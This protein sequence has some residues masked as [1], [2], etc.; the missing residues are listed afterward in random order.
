MA[1][2]RVFFDG[3]IRWEEEAL[4]SP[5]CTGLLYGDGLF[6]VLRGYDGVPFRLTD[7]YDRLRASC[8]ALRL[9]LLYD[10][11]NLWLIIRELLRQND[12]TKGDS[13][14]RIT[15]FGSEL[16]TISS[17]DGLTTHTF[18]HVRPFSPPRPVK[19]RTGVKVRVSSYRTS[20]HNPTAGHNTICFLPMI[21]ARRA[22][23]ERGLDEVLVQNTEGGITEGTTT[24][25]FI[26][27]NG[28]IITPP[29]DDGIRLDVAR[30]VVLELASEEGLDC[31]E[32]R[33]SPK[34]LKGA[35]EIFIANSLIEIM[36][37]KE[38]DG[39]KIGNGSAGEVT[40]KLIKGYR[41]KVKQ[42]CS[43]S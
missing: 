12:A 40:K 24:N 34:A 19:Y 14:I 1:R 3:A 33:I 39:E 10:E 17:A 32:R 29:A 2:S 6:D 36:P 26:V 41:K 13:Y 30:K 22:A 21:L 15:V 7:H 37:V 42:E 43:R 11:E 27:K 16:N 31:S 23:W 18:V 8:E 38:V 35:D 20:P 25:L 28:R 4:I 9:N 5:L